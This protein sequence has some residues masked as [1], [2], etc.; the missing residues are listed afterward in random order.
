MPINPKV[1]KKDFPSA[2]T[3]TPF[4]VTLAVTATAED[5]VSVPAL[6]KGRAVSLVNEGPGEVA[7]AFDATATTSDLFL[8]E[9]DAYDEHDLE[10]STNI[11]FINVTTGQTPRVRGILWSGD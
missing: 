3:S 11:S 10:V 7:I 2:D 5:L 4:D 8:E 6:K 9:G 1:A